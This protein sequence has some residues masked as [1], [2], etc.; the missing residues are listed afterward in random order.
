[1]SNKSYVRNG[2]HINITVTEDKRGKWSWHYT[3]GAMGYT[4]MKDRP[5]PAAEIAMHEA[6][7]D[8]NHKADRLPTGNDSE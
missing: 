8:A 5:L 7:N 6:E 2:H 4:E 3:I 1:M